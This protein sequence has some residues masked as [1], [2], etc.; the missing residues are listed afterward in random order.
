M[1]LDRDARPAD[2][3]VGP[4]LIVAQH[5]NKEGITMSVI[6][7][8]NFGYQPKKLPSG[9]EWNL[10]CVY[11]N[12][13]GEPDN[14]DVRFTKASP[15]GDATVVIEN[16]AIAAIAKPNMPVYLL[17]DEVVEDQ[18]GPSWKGA[19]AAA[20]VNCH[21]HTDFGGTTGR[22]E[23]EASLDRQ[24]QIPTAL[25]FAERTTLSIRIGIDNPPAASYFKP[26]KLYFVRFY[27]A[28]ELSQN[29]ALRLA[30]GGE[31]ADA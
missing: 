6:A 30:H 5:P 29:Q 8:M 12:R 22:V 4:V 16:P 24:L 31:L 14:E 17:F 19:F 7:K 9:D 2:S 20:L 25:R 26:K 3:I 27:D 10:S 23:F 18:P 11:D 13:I 1:V 28:Y 21:S 15:W